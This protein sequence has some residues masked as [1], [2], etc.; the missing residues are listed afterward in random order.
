MTKEPMQGKQVPSEAELD[1]LCGLP[2]EEFN[3]IVQETF[4][5]DNPPVRDIS[6]KDQETEDELADR[7]V[8]EAIAADRRAAEGR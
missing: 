3:A 8:D 1:E 4:S 5:E 2:P 7:L 6:H